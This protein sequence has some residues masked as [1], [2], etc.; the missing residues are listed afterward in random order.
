MFI[1]HFFQINSKWLCPQWTCR[2]QYERVFAVYNIAAA[3]ECTTHGHIVAYINCF[4]FPMCTWK[5]YVPQRSLKT[6]TSITLTTKQWISWIMIATSEFLSFFLSFSLAQCRT[7]TAILHWQRLMLRAGWFVQAWQ[8]HAGEQQGH[9][10]IFSR[11]P[12]SSS[13]NLL[14]YAHATLRLKMLFHSDKEYRAWVDVVERCTVSFRGLE[15]SP[16]PLM[17]AGPRTRMQVWRLIATRCL[18]SQLC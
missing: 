12:T 3:V 18:Y 16:T 1:R 11:I 8:N 14:I 15:L 13:Q 9:R 6:V 5:K 2:G 7:H 4:F 10:G 17:H